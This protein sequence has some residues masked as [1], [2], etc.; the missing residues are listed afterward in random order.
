MQV[1][2]EKIVE[3]V[4]DIVEN[5]RGTVDT[6]LAAVRQ[7]TA[8][9]QASVE[10]MVKDVAGMVTDVGG[11]V[12]DVRATVDT[13]LVAVRQGIAGTQASVGEI[14][15]HV[16]GTVGETVATVQAHL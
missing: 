15:E 11:M 8:G 3:D 14:V 5:V 6:T 10:E 9:T 13:T 12:K 16:K 1:S 4:G 7:G 2:V